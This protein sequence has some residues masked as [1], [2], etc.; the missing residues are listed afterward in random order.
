[1]HL[2]Q[3]A[4]K[5]KAHAQ[6]GR[7]L[8]LFFGLAVALGGCAQWSKESASTEVARPILAP[9]Q[10]SPDSVVVESVVVRFPQ[11]QLEVIEDLWKRVDESILPMQVRRELAANGLR[12]GVIEN[13]LPATI[14]NRLNELSDASV[15]GTLEQAGLAADIENLA[16]R[17]QCR[18]GVRKEVHVRREL[19]G[20]AI[21]ICN[22]EGNMEGASYEDAAMLFDMRTIPHGDGTAT[23]NLTPEI[24]H[25]EARKTFV[26]SDVGMRPEMRRDQ[27]SWEQLK[28]KAKL[29]QGQ[30]LVIGGNGQP[31]APNLGRAFFVTHTAESSDEQALLLV[32]LAATQLDE[33]FHPEGVRAAQ[34][35]SE[36]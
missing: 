1:M 22:R 19:L 10:M 3:R 24:Q 6:H 26:T 36:R 34:A 33:L 20:P 28:I 32:R 23:L 27:K 30:I 21:V 4:R 25:G 11:T 7:W 14:R 31:T 2:N 12:C 18:A 16:N 8:L 15:S 13:E 9:P 5:R 17:F 29:R 35:A